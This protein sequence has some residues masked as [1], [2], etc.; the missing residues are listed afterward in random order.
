L[1]TAL[2]TADDAVLAQIALVK[3][4][5]DLLPSDP[6]DQSLII[7]ATDAIIAAIG[8]VPT[9]AELATALGTADDAV[10]LAIDGLPTALENADALLD[11]A[12][13]IETGLTPRQMLK[14]SAAVLLGKASGGGTGTETF[15]SAVA[16]D[17]DRVVSTNDASGNR[18]AVTTN[19]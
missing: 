19:L 2:G 9:N 14:G 18:T 11:R 17:A 13:A 8:D 4:Q 6:A 1:T 10:L 5:T 15:R 16:D 12:D 3:A 7:A